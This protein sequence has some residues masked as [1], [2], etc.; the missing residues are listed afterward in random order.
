MP[1]KQSKPRRIPAPEP[2]V[3][4]GTPREDYFAWDAL[5]RGEIV[6]FDSQSP[7]QY[8]YDLVNERKV[9]D[10]MNHGSAVDCYVFDGEEAFDRQ[11]YRLKPGVVRNA[12]QQPYKDE[13]KNA[14]GR[15]ILRHGDYDSARL[16][17]ELVRA[18]EEVAELL[19]DGDAQLCVVAD[20]PKT[21]IRCKAMIDF[22]SRAKGDPILLDLKR[23]KDWRADAFA[24]S[25]PSNRLYWQAAWYTRVISEA[26]Q[27]EHSQFGFFCIKP[28][29]VH[30]V[31]VHH[32]SLSAMAVGNDEIDAALAR[33]KQCRDENRWPA[34][35]PSGTVDLPYWKYREYE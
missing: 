31:A 28:T 25:L 35:V 24:R 23:T 34:N 27:F 20:D 22:Y 19:S 2:G 30:S 5:S 6:T 18:H 7:A 16:M 11:F 17:G 33:F 10:D 1:K 4:P 26:M 15:T 14:A 9:T 3:Y 32:L 8:M 21:G 12:K 13:I 29:P